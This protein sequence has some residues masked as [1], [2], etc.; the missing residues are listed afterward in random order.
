LPYTR[1]AGLVLGMTE[2]EIA[3]LRCY[4]PAEVVRLLNIPA[5]RLKT[6]V[7]TGCRTSAPVSNVARGSPLRTSGRSASCC[8]S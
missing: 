8:P 4:K 5:K 2:D 6:W 3:T 1:A 7:Q